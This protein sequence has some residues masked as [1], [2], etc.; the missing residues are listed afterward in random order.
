MLDIFGPTSYSLIFLFLFLLFLLFSIC[1]HLTLH[2][3]E[4]GSFGSD[5]NYVCARLPALGLEHLEPIMSR[6]HMT[7]ERL[8]TLSDDDL[9]SIGV[10]VR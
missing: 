2:T 6:E 7:E 3:Q 8:M 10:K 5:L 9:I 1:V 4:K